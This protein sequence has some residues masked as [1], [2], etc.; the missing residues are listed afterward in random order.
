MHNRLRQ[1]K[2]SISVA[3][4]LP[5]MI[6]E[7]YLREW[8]SSVTHKNYPRESPTRITDEFDPHEFN[9]RESPTSFTHAI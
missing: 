9:P 5:R 7:F 6:R 3:Y 1:K 8:P 4:V 2:N